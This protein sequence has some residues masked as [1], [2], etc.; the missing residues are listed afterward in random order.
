MRYLLDRLKEPGT[1]RSLAVVLFALLGLTSD[2][3]RLEAA[4]QVAILALGTLSAVIPEK[5]AQ[6]A[7]KIEGAVQTAKEIA[8]IAVATTTEAR[9]ATAQAAQVVES[10]KSLAESVAAGDVR[11]LSRPA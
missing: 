11:P 8:T 3:A 5:S 4:I 6:A 7:A 9:Q 1:M 10:T 2:D